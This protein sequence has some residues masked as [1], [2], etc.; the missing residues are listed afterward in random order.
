MTSAFDACHL[1][2][3]SSSSA[4]GDVSG[5]GRIGGV[6][7]SVLGQVDLEGAIGRRWLGH[8]GGGRGPA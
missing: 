5:I 2:R 3:W 7:G 6:G 8:R 1:E 4:E